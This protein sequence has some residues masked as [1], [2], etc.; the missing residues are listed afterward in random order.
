MKNLILLTLVIALVAIGCKTKNKSDKEEEAAKTELRTEI[1]K[2]EKELYTAKDFDADKA[3]TMIGKYV[4]YSEKFPDDTTSMVFLLKASEIALSID[5]PH[6]AIKYLTTIEK[7][8]LQFK[9]YPV[10]I[11]YLG[12]TYHNFL[13]DKANARKYYEMFLAKYP[14]HSLA[15]DA[16]ASIKYLGLSDEELIETFEEMNK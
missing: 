15:D 1:E 7:S 10:A 4:Y 12:F 5:Q 6:N 14:N 3:K 9:D 16:E 8:G 2:L 13:N 11:F